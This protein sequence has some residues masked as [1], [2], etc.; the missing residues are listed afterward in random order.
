MGHLSLICERWTDDMAARFMGYSNVQQVYKHI[1]LV[2]HQV[3]VTVHG[4]CGLHELCTRPIYFRDDTVHETSMVEDCH[5]V[6]KGHGGHFIGIWGFCWLNR[7]REKVCEKNK[8]NFQS[9]LD[10]GYEYYL[11]SPDINNSG[12][13]RASRSHWT[14]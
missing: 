6:R 7:C 14:R 5:R 8:M 3:V 4:E 13:Q 12:R 2:Y 10:L 9:I 11:H 1:R